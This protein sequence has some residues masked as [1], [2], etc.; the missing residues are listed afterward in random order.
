MNRITN[1]ELS[2]IDGQNY[3]IKSPNKFSI[4]QSPTTSYKQTQ[5]PNLHQYPEGKLFN[6]SITNQNYIPYLTSSQETS[7]FFMPRSKV[8]EEVL[9]SL[10]TNKPSALARYSTP[11]KYVQG[12]FDR[13]FE[14]LE[15]DRLEFRSSVPSAILASEKNRYKFPLIEQTDSSDGDDDFNIDGKQMK[16][17][18]EIYDKRNEYGENNY[19]GK[20]EGNCYYKEL[21]NLFKSQT[22]KVEHQPF[23]TISSSQKPL[24]PEIYPFVLKNSA[25]EGWS[26]N[27]KSRLPAGSVFTSNESGIKTVESFEP[28]IR[29]ELIDKS[30]MNERNRGVEG[31]ERFESD[32]EK[33][34]DY[35]YLQ[36]LKIRASAVC[37][38]LNDHK[39]YKNW[40]KNWKL[41]EKNL[42]RNG[43]LFQRLDDTDSD[44]AYVINKGDKVGFRIRDEKRYVP[45]NIYQYVLYHEMAHMSTE[46]L[47]HTDKFHELL[48]IITLAGFEL[49]F[50]DLSRMTKEFYLTNGQPIICSASMKDEIMD[51]CDWLISA[52]PHS[53]LYYESIKKAIRRF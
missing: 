13:S 33:D 8:K 40:H 50:I 7:P 19:V 43:L 27:D 12:Y 49:G 35:M 39:S 4:A 6:K 20:I 16:L 47:Q 26:N 3:I 1:S 18:G 25:N 11:G 38:F 28:N 29:N 46:E 37:K 17:K 31:K 45:L 9:D 48:N 21:N 14:S 32:I 15:N 51:G 5:I 2:Y 23:G 30:R 24:Y 53:K 22:M 52:N 41:L 10:N 42:K 34:A 44:I 36:A